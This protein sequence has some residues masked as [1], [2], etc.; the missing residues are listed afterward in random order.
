MRRPPGKLG[1]Q[2]LAGAELR[3]RTIKNFKEMLL[4]VQESQRYTMILKSF[5][6]DEIQLGDEKVGSL[7]NIESSDGK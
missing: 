1:L 2:R 6:E 3:A 7:D 5:V 4:Q